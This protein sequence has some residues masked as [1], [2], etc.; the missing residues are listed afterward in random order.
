MPIQ[1]IIA[2]A[3]NEDQS[4]IMASLELSAAFDVVNLELLLK[5]MTIL[6]LPEDLIS[7]V[8]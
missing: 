7:L 3:L 4:A 8:S 6:G 5:R 2:R 1:L